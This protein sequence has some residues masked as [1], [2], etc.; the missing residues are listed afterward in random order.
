MSETVLGG[1]TETTTATTQATTTSATQSW[2][3]SLPEDLKSHSSLSQIQDVNALARSYV[4]AQSMVGK[5]GVFKPSDTASEEEWSSFY[6]SIGQP[7]LEKFD[8]ATPAEGNK[9]FVGDF[10]NVAHKAGLLPKQAQSVMD[11][12]MKKE[13]DTVA[14]KTQAEKSTVEEGINSLK[15]EWGGGFEKQ[16]SLAK[17]AV[18]EV[19]GDEFTAYLESSGLGNNPALIKVLSKVGK[20]LGEDKIRGDAT[21]SM[22]GQ[23]PDEIQAEI[24]AIMGNKDHPYYNPRHPSNGDATKKM[25]ALFQKLHG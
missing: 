10:K 24:N 5:K 3:D 14:A 18:K 7:D 13:S 11:W 19:G 9:E 17:L 12:L 21:G 22:G 15:K 2:K 4:H 20:L 1:N 6:K 8:I 23:T 16:I 25:A